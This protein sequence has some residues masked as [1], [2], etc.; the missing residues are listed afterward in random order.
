MKMVYT[1]CIPVE[2]PASEGGVYKLY[3]SEVAG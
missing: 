3:S 2:L 1:C